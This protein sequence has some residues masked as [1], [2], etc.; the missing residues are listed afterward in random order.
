[1]RPAIA[2]AAAALAFAVVAGAATAPAAAWGAQ[3]DA[4]RRPTELQAFV[5]ASAP[6]SLADLE[7]H[8][9]AVGV[10]YPTFFEC[11][12]S[13]GAITGE[14][15]GAITAYAD[16]HGIAVMPRFNCQDG[17]TVHSILT[18]PQVRART[19]A[20]LIGIAENRAYAGLNLDL[21]NDGAADR[22]ALSRFVATLA[23]ELHV[24]GKK[25]AVDVDGVTHEDARI[26][27][28][29]YDDRALGAAADYVFVMAWGTHWE[30]SA[31]GP[32]AP[33]P[34]VAAVAAHVASLPDA[35]RFV[36]GA[37]L[38]G[39]DWPV[40]GDRSHPA[41]ALRDEAVLALARSSDA[42]PARDRA[43]DELTFAYTRAGVEHRVWYLD[44]R[45]VADR[46]R[47]ARRYGL[48]VGVWR[49]GGEDQALWS[50]APVIEGQLGADA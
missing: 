32:I 29:L 35:D 4:E 22:G 18:D 40:G 1:V 43:V 46:L 15:S 8:A 50:S 12:P 13:S 34:F 33:L 28:G 16:A 23:G 11:E 31:P 2:A 44:A 47:I 41:T 45:A 19:L 21:E 42:T 14:D 37:P 48:A 10:V 3:A 25:L 49:L 36:L 39:L 20:G 27:T 9:E 38:Y 6:D 24:H 5:L 17:A 26:A 30:G 7:A